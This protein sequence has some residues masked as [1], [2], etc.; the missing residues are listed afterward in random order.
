MCWLISPVGL[1]L[2]DEAKEVMNKNKSVKAH[3]K[4]IKS[5]ILEL[6]TT[7][8]EKEATYSHT[9]ALIENVK[10]G[11]ERHEQYHRTEM[12]VTFAAS[13]LCT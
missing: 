9:R 7:I 11:G 12:K 6:E 10:S 1:K 5:D 4:E 13:K 8:R 2:L 3:S